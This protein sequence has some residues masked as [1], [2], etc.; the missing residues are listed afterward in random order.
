M[1]VEEGFNADE[2]VGEEVASGRVCGLYL[3]VQDAEMDSVMI[4]ITIE[5][6]VFEDRASLYNVT[7]YTCIIYNYRDREGSSLDSFT[8][9]PHTQSPKAPSITEH[10]A[11]QAYCCLA[12]EEQRESEFNKKDQTACVILRE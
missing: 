5:I 4:A 12:M 10:L 3:H 7:V 1:L 6:C 11:H 9:T 2:V 8:R